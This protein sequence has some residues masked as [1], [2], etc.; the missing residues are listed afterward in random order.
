MKAAPLPHQDYLNECF[1]YHE[2]TGKLFWKYR[3]RN[4]FNT[5]RGYNMWNSKNAGNLID[6][7]DATGYIRFSLDSV[8]T[9][10]HRVIWKMLHNEEPEHIDHIN[11][12]R[13][14]NRKLNMRALSHGENMKN[15]A[16]YSNNSTTVMGVTKAH[17]R[18]GYIVRIGNQ[19]VGYF[20]D[21]QE[22]VDARFRAELGENYHANHGRSG[23][24]LG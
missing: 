11:G 10:A 13:W 12:I 24:S 23:T 14:D 1:E 17:N 20:T 7:R 6:G 5:N 4:H 2:D 16:V 8:K 22:A 15:K 3:P 19:Y 21:F 18:E 9:L